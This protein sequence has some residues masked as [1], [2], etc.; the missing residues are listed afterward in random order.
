MILSKYVCDMKDTIIEEK[1]IKSKIHWRIWR[2]V[3]NRVH[4]YCL[5]Q[6][7]KLEIILFE[8]YTDLLNKRKEILSGCSSDQRYLLSRLKPVAKG[9]TVNK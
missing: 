3:V 6:E 7:E 9:E 5:C 2:K 1:K 4:V 8:N